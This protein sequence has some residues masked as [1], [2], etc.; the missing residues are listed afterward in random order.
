MKNIYVRCKSDCCAG[1]VGAIWS[2]AKD[3]ARENRG[4]SPGKMSAA[5]T[6]QIGNVSA[7]GNFDFWNASIL[8]KFNP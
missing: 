1:F 8:P 7:A 6:L 2:W 5:C 4:I 3:F